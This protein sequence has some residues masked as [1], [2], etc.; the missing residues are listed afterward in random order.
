[1]EYNSS[2][3]IVVSF[4]ANYVEVEIGKLNQNINQRSTRLLCTRR[5]RLRYSGDLVNV[6]DEVSVAEIDWEH[7]TGVITSVKPR[8]NLLTRPN[9]ANVSHIVVAL[10][11]QN[12]LF[13]LDQASRFL[14]TAEQID[15]EICLVLTKIDLLDQ[16]KV[17]KRI[18]L[19]NSWGY[20]PIG[21]SCKTGE[22][23]DLLIASLNSARLAVLCGPSGVGKSSLLNCLIP[24][25]SVPVG[26]LSSRLQRGKNTTSNVELFAFTN[27]SLLADTPGFN[28]P[29]ITVKPNEL[30]YLFPE[31][32]NQLIKSPCKFRDCLHRDE[33]GCGVDKNWERYS[34]YLLCLEELLTLHR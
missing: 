32:R 33:L 21:V 15:L 26:S 29:E 5:N 25:A 12:P 10:S 22:G 18:S 9:V 24:E 3:G 17:R 28:K 30:A 13:D 27:K 34:S 1:M 4:K 11:L 6:G 7:S 31:L 20:D 16:K 23:L 8:F 2:S 14:L 19:C